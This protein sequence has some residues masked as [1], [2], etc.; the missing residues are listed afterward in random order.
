MCAKSSPTGRM[1][2]SDYEEP[3]LA[4]FPLTLVDAL[5]ESDR[6]LTRTETIGLPRGCRK[7]AARGRIFVTGRQRHRGTESSF[8]RTPGLSP[9]RDNRSRWRATLCEPVTQPIH[10]PTTSH[11]RARLRRPTPATPFPEER[12]CARPPRDDSF[13]DSFIASSHAFEISDSGVIQRRAP[14]RPT[15]ALPLSGASRSRRRVP[16]CARGRRSRRGAA[17]CRFAARG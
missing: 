13:I 15:A 4:R 11:E 7:I 2:G 17:G 9:L 6:P 5:G 12:S 16:C 8:P 14:R 3:P 10:F 1:P